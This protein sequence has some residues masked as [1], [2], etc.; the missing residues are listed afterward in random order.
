MLLESNVTDIHSST[1]FSYHLKF[2][3]LS[4]WEEPPDVV[5]QSQ[6]PLD[7]AA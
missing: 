1:I 3:V 6:K 7:L 5:Y 2:E 4:F